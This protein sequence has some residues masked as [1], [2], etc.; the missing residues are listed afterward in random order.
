MILNIN[1]IIIFPSFFWSGDAG[2]TPTSRRGSRDGLVRQCILVCHVELNSY[3]MFQT[4]NMQIEY[5][6]LFSFQV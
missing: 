4:K 3:F 5:Y 6:L 1:I 2:G